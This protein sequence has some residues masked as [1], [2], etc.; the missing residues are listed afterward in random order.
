MN[1]DRH[2]LSGRGLFGWRRL[3]IALPVAVACLTP[4]PAHAASLQEVTKLLT[5][6]GVVMLFA[7][8]MVVIAYGLNVWTSKRHRRSHHHHE[9]R[10]FVRRHRTGVVL[11]CWLLLWLVAGVVF[12]L[13][14]L[15]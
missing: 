4:C 9:E 8:L 5:L 10:S 1:T 12:Y 6:A 11:G 7:F 14:L 2:W 3:V 15:R 13:V